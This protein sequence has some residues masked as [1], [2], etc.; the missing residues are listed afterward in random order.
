MDLRLYLVAVLDKKAA[1]CAR[2]DASTTT[3]AYEIPNSHLLTRH[4]RMVRCYPEYNSLRKRAG[5]TYRHHLFT[6]FRLDGL[7]G[8]N[9]SN[10]LD[11]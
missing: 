5:D 2:K 10:G 9:H 1:G 3:A 4:C 6:E 11:G 8:D 7:C